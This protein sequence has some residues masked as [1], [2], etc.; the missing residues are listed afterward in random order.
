MSE[1]RGRRLLIVLLAAIGTGA[2]T[3]TVTGAMA[4]YGHGTRR[5]PHHDALPTPIPRPAVTTPSP[6][7]S[8]KPGLSDARRRRLA[9]DIDKYLDGS[10]LAVSIRDL[11]SGASFGYHDKDDFA[12]ASI[13]K[14]D[15]LSTLLLQAQQ[16]GRSLTDSEKSTAVQMI[17]Y[18]DNNA[19]TALWDDIGGSSGLEEGNR[20]LGLRNTVPGEGVYW[21][22][23]DTCTADQLRLLSALTSPKS[24]L[25]GSARNYILHLMSS[26]TPSQ[27]WGVSAGAGSGD[28]V[29]L[30]NGW[31]S[32][33][34][35][36]GAW[37]VNSIGRI[38][39]GGHD[40]LIA[41]M[42][43][44]SSSMDAGVAEIEHVTKLVVAAFTDGHADA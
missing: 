30:K 40:F 17:E 19:A 35:D 15:I 3:A 33:P 5:H 41:V 39:G 21:G 10:P 16:A 28:S 12:T 14:V 42:S 31:L 38:R 22:S 24:P 29:A 9:H 34:R 23:T 7:P 20:R 18:S 2:I 26:V 36:N 8:P 25:R 43:S 13:V 11:S 37:A 6:T 1:T 27:A 4:V 44:H 32:R